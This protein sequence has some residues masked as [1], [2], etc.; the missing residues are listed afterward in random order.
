MQADHTQLLREKYNGKKTDAFYRDAEQLDRG[1][2]LAYVI[3]HI[4]FLDTT[5]YL[6]SYPLIPRP[7]TEYWTEAVIQEMQ[8]T[9][10]K[11]PRVLDLC[12]GSGCIGVAI[13]HALPN[14]HVTFAEIDHAHLST[15]TKN[16]E[17]NIPE[18]SNRM[19]YYPV[20]QSDLFAN[21]HETFDWILANPPYIDPAL[22]RT[23]RSVT[24]HEPHKALY[25]GN[26][27][28][29]VI[30][31]VITSAPSYLTKTGVLIIEHEPEQSKQIHELAHEHGF[32]ATVHKDQYGIERYARLE[33]SH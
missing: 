33:M 14:A 31:R 23:E 30:T 21:I 28:I 17:S 4:P 18:Y 16:L 8:K 22:D 32:T 27:G 24:E 25:G 13:A 19:E 20:V 1:E 6:D 9:K 29:D 11:A 2:P 5:I 12:A 3:G 15:I 10:F 7:E 26:G